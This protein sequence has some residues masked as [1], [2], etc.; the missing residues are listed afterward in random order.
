[1][2]DRALP[3]GLFVQAQAVRLGAATVHPQQA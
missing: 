3:V 1:M 2:R